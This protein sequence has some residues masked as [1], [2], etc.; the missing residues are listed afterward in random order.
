[1][2]TN[3][4]EI[5]PD[6]E[7]GYRLT[8]SQWFANPV[9]EIFS[10]FSDAMQLE[11]ITPPLLQ[12]S[13]QTPQPIVI[14]EGTIL[15]YQLKLHGIPIRWRSEICVWQPN[16]RFVDQQLKGPYKKWYHEHL[17]E[18]VDGGTLVTDNVHYIPRGGWLIHEFLVKPDLEKIFRFRQNKL[19]EIFPQPV[20]A[21]ETFVD[22]ERVSM[23][24]SNA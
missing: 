5:M 7:K 14:A 19:S 20:G 16:R 23:E 13:V 9:D 17:F 3:S 21:R 4:I 10:F 12:F 18:S 8:A 22:R 6:P 1:M 15:D 24:M 11:N 2:Q